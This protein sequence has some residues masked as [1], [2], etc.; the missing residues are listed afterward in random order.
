M[1]RRAMERHLPHVFTQC[2]LPLDR[3]ECASP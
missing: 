2:Y 3:G 1:H